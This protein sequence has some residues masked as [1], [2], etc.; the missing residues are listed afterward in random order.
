M[1]ILM[2]WFI[3]VAL[4]V[5]LTIGIYLGFRLLHLF[6]FDRKG[7]FNG[8]GRKIFWLVILL[9]SLSF[10]IGRSLAPVDGFWLLFIANYLFA[11]VICL[12]YAMLLC[13]VIYLISRVC[14]YW[15]KS[16]NRFSHCIN[17]YFNQQTRLWQVSYILLAGVIFIVGIYSANVPQAR[18]YQLT[19]NKQ[20]KIDKVRI[21][22]LSDIHISA[23]TSTDW[24]NEMV[25]K[26]NHL[27]PDYI[28]I[29]GDTLDQ[30]LAPYINNNLDTI[31]AQLTSRYGTLVIFGNHEYYGIARNQNNSNDDVLS[32][33][34]AGK[35][36]IL[37][38]S[39]WFDNRTGIT[40]IG[41]DDLTGSIVGKSRATLDELIDLVAPDS[42]IILLDHQPHDL[43][44]PEQLGVDLMLSGHTHAGQIFPMTL[45]VQALYRNAWGIYQLNNFTSIVSSGYGIWGPPMRLLTRAEL[46]VVDINFLAE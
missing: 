5:S 36:T 1:Y 45:I 39:V 15:G 29:T 37:Q 38:D 22:Q 24:L 11:L 9:C 14:I 27:A 7:Y 32:A 43:T 10:L 16:N 8:Y 13:D 18:F 33:F 19:I 35:M 31:F 20:A 2:S 3:F 23:I 44:T 17:R 34:A 41:R 28:I 42:P 30:Q 25:E 4:G 6:A 26:V 46:V 12:F 40:I 21:V